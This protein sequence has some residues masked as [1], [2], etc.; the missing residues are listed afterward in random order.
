MAN[1]G[2]ENNGLEM[3]NEVLKSRGDEGGNDDEIGGEYFCGL[4]VLVVSSGILARPLHLC[5]A[6]SSS[7]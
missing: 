2:A 4:L 3:E 7:N 6:S 1:R 5:F